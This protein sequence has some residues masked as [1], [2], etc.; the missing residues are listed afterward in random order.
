MIRF[1]ITKIFGLAFVLLLLTACGGSKK[2]EVVTHVTPSG[3]NLE[4]CQLYFDGCNNCQVENGQIT[5]CTKKYCDQAAMGR[6]VC[7][8]E[9]NNDAI[10]V[11]SVV[12]N[13]NRSN[14]W[15]K[16][17]CNSLGGLFFVDDAAGTKKCVGITPEACPTIGGGYY[18]DCASPCEYLPE[19]DPLCVQK[20]IGL[21]YIDRNGTME[22]PR[23]IYGDPTKIQFNG[24][25]PNQI[26]SFPIFLTGKVA[27][28]WPFEGNF[29]IKVLSERKKVL[30]E[31]FLTANT[32]DPETGER[33]ADQM[34]EFFGE[35]YA[36]PPNNEMRGF[37]RFERHNA[38][39]LPQH[40]EWVDIPIR[41][42]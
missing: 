31:H 14:H 5:A 8:E 9:V 11:D 10:E 19:V 16:T 4:N 37:I 42:R 26:T 17:Q 18:N 3:T 36:A 13:T 1:C 7:L 15:Y 33:I 22:L 38:S 39:G 28:H 25:Q 41:F 23:E 6:P 27:P 2:S 12:L 35:I 34:V 20:C 21:C 30:A 40:A 32:Y 24:F 29:G